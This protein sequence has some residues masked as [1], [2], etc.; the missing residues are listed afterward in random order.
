MIKT[1]NLLALMILRYGLLYVGQVWF[2]TVILEF[3][4]IVRKMIDIGL[5]CMSQKSET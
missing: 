5:I 4:I 2:K 3:E 1:N